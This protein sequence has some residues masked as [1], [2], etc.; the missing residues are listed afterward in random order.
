MASDAGPVYS[1]ALVRVQRA[2]RSAVASGDRMEIEA[3]LATL[4][5]TFV[6]GAMG[7]S[8]DAVELT[9]DA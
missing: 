5:P 7:V 8:T 2:A 1:R 9:P 6:P 4:I 3:V